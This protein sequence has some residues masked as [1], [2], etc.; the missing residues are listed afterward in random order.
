LKAESLE[1]LK[2]VSLENLKEETISYVVLCCPV[3]FPPVENYYNLGFLFE[4]NLDFAVTNL[5]RVFDH[6]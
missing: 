2:V 4:E 5:I 6:A 1:N 3:N